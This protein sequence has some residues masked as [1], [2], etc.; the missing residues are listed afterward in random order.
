LR[1]AAG[2]EGNASSSIT[3]QK[4]ANGSRAGKRQLPADAVEPF[5]STGPADSAFR[6]PGIRAEVES[7]VDPGEIGTRNKALLP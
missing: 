3:E 1:P 2:I 4:P 5:R 7:V 6:A